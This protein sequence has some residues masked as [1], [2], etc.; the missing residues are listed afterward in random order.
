MRLSPLPAGEYGEFGDKE[1]P[2]EGTPAYLRS[3]F[4]FSGENIVGET[5]RSNG[6][7]LDVGDGTWQS[8]RGRRSK[9]KSS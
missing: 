1:D 2:G 6:E 8:E 4:E 7:R 3:S 5:G 9:S